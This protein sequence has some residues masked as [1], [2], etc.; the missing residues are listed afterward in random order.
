MLGGNR[1]WD[2]LKQA[3]LEEENKIKKSGSDVDSMYHRLAKSLSKSHREVPV[4]R[5]V[6]VVVCEFSGLC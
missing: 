1:P 3:M 5:S 2:V 4:K 6:V